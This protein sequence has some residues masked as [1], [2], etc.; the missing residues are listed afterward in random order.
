MCWAWGA[1]VAST[2]VTAKTAGAAAFATA[3]PLRSRTGQGTSQ[4]EDNE[5]TPATDSCDSVIHSIRRR[6]FRDH[7]RDHSW[8]T[9]H[10]SATRF[11]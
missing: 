7:L 4:G 11:G 5:S 1:A 9:S 3:E 2:A 6:E 8:D 10:H